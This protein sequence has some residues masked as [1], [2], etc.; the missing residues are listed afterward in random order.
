M[1]RAVDKLDCTLPDCLFI[2]DHMLLNL[3]TMMLN[4]RF[5][6]HRHRVIFDKGERHYIV[7]HS[8][9]GIEYDVQ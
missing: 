4:Q 8:R 1:S 3:L 2:A 6:L 5:Q 7:A 9:R